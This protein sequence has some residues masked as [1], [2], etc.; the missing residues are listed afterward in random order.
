MSEALEVPQMKCAVGFS[1][2]NFASQYLLL[3][4]FTFSPLNLIVYIGCL[5]L[6]NIGPQAT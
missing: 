1:A 5:A 6:N 2:Q 4:L 3:D